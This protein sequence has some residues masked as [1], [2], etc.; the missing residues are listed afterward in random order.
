MRHSY[1]SALNCSVNRAEAFMSATLLVEPVIQ[2]SIHL[3]TKPEP[4]I[5]VMAKVQA[6]AEENPLVI[7]FVACVIA[8]H[9]AV[10][11]IGSVAAWL[12]YLRHSGAFAP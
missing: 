11:M 12:Y 1:I 2:E 4:E 9:L 8:F 3:A 5:P 7:V 6:K 10:A